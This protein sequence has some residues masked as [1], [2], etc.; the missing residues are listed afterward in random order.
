VLKFKKS[1]SDPKRLKGWN[2][3]RQDNKMCFYRGRHE[4]FKD[5]YSQEDGECFA[6]I[7]VPLWKFLAVNVTQISGT[8][9]LIRQK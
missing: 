6:M 5:F 1:N 8:C 7:S 2:L 9:P 3:L 4:E